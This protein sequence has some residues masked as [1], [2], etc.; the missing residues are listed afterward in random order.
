VQVLSLVSVP[1]DRF[2]NAQARPCSLEFVRLVASNLFAFRSIESILWGYHHFEYSIA[3]TA[4]RQR[5]CT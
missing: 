5:C 2:F 4:C 1:F 3:A